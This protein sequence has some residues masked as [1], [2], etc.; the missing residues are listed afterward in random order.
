MI[1]CCRW[2]AGRAAAP[3]LLL[4]PPTPTA[5]PPRPRLGIDDLWAILPLDPA[6][7]GPGFGSSIFGVDECPDDVEGN[8]AGSDLIATACC[9]C[10][11]CCCCCWCRGSGVEIELDDEWFEA[12]EEVMV[13]LGCP[14]SAARISSKIFSSRIAWATMS[15]FFS[16]RL[17]I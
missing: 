6:D 11:C 5:P 7:D 1:C 3:P 4:L 9:C 17:N 8:T 13:F 12:S 15:F 16:W 14:A 2:I 10:C